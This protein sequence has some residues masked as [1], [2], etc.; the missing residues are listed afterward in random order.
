MHAEMK[1][2]IRNSCFQVVKENRKLIRIGPYNTVYV[3]DL[4]NQTFMHERKCLAQ[5]ILSANDIHILFMIH[6]LI[7]YKW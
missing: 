5:P 2:N 3:N 7:I 6:A 4:S 1:I